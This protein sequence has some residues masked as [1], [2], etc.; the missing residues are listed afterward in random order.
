MPLTVQSKGPN[1]TIL[2]EGEFKVE[3]AE[4]SFNTL[5]R[6]F[7]TKVK[8]IEFDFSGITGADISFFQLMCSAHREALLAG[9]TLKATLL[10]AHINETLK[11]LGF[12]HLDG[13]L[14]KGK[15][16]CLW[17]SGRDSG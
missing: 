1:T 8:E 2:A 6:V 12:I 5:Q 11:G 13:C 9:I 3:D 14:P 15:E 7:T 4:E 10:P 16:F 17:A